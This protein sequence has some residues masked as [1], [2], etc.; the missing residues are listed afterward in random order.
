M[1]YSLVDQVVV[2]MLDA[3]TMVPLLESVHS[4]Y[5][6]CLCWLL[7]S[8]LPY[9][10]LRWSLD[11]IHVLGWMVSYRFEQNKHCLVVEQNFWHVLILWAF[12]LKLACSYTGNK[13]G[14]FLYCDF[15]CFQMAIR[16]ACSYTV[17]FFLL[18]L[19]CSY[20]L[21]SFC[22]DILWA[23]IYYEQSLGAFC[24][25]VDSNGGKAHVVC[26][27]CVCC[28]HSVLERHTFCAFFFVNCCKYLK[29]SACYSQ[30][31]DSFV[32][33]WEMGSAR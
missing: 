7:W 33:R 24:A 31:V 30:N 23:K 32:F 20:T 27:L 6:A 10:L 13:I 29:M 15:Y 2:A 19:A 3:K 12:L 17:S 22:K 26:I 14:M 4:I 5:I 16:L 18:K 9:W 25:S 21:S 28:R 8:A 1:A 11:Q